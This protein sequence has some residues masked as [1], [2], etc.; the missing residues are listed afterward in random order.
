MVS[1]K[2]SAIAGCLVVA[3]LLTPGIANMSVVSRI[4]DGPQTSQSPWVIESG[5]TNE[6]DALK[7]FHAFWS[8]AKPAPVCCG[9][10]DAKME[11][12]AVEMRVES[13][14]AGELLMPYH[15]CGYT[16]VSMG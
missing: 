7:A 10:E 9:Q 5:F 12:I 8:S 1:Q 3:L 15:A 14:N 16:A 11:S 13:C 4:H 6:A 2:I